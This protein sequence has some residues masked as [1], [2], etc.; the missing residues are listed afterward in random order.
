MPNKNDIVTAIKNSNIFL[1]VPELN[2]AT[3]KLN[4]DG[5]P[6]RFTGGFTMVFQLTKNSKKWAFRVWHIG[7]NKQK[8]RFLKI[9]KYLENQ[10]LPYFA[11][12]IYDEKGLLVNGELVDTIRMEWLDGD[13][14]KKY[15]EKNISNEN[16]LQNLANNFLTIFDLLHKHK[17][18]HGDLQHGNILI[19]S[20]DNIRLIDYDSVC[21]P[22]IE[23]KEE[24]V[25][26]LRGY[27]HPS[28]L[29]Y[30]SKAS[31]KADFF[32]E[33]IIYLS[34]YAI[35]LNPNLWDKY[36]VKDTEVLLFND[37]DFGNLQQS[38]IYKDLMS[39]NSYKINVLLK[40]LADYLNKSSYLELEPFDTYKDF[41]AIKYDIESKLIKRYQNVTKK[42]E[43]PSVS[44]ISKYCNQCGKPYNKPTSNFCSYC[45]KKRN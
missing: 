4:F 14:L 23:G 34:L 37:E 6:F 9:S 24:L 44:T 12:F 36:N 16:K 18:S 11:D 42:I 20:Q 15:I 29:K 30:A 19:D 35:I 1:K 3:V 21:V 43:N 32:S 7:F 26:G 28:R 31:L 25:T 13:L 27:Q 22:E 40:I 10:K 45:G 38:D 2:G 39:I 41:V 33:L 8:D 5:Q 17:I